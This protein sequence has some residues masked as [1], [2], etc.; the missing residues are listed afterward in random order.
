M[1]DSIASE[2]EIQSLLVPM[3]QKPLLLPIACLAE[4]V[5]YFRPE[6]SSDGDDWY[7][8]DIEWRGVLIPLVSFERF[9]QHRF[10]EF[11]ATAKI[12]IMNKTVDTAKHGFYGVVIQG[13]PQPLTLVRGD[14]HLSKDQLGPA[15]IAR[16]IVRDL[17]ATIPD[18]E[19]LEEQLS[20]LVTD[21]A[22]HDE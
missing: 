15:E 4:V 20:E 17:P 16:V 9:N 10:T 18:L 8:G 5:D 6:N 22:G 2:R 3:Q 11:S 21:A 19:E 1:T 13:I 14:I 12:A 7:L